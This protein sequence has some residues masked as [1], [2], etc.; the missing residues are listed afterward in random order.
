MTD[1]NQTSDEL[2]MDSCENAYKAGLNDRTK[3]ILL[4][5]SE[6]AIK[7]EGDRVCGVLNE[8]DDRIEALIK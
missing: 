7:W 2:K 4:I 3:T 8:I 6:Y 5:I 1:T